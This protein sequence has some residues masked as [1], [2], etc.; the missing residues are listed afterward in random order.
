M[1]LNPFLR[2]VG[3]TFGF[4]WLFWVLAVMSGLDVSD[5]LVIVLFALG[6]I[7]PTVGGVVMTYLMGGRESLQDLLRRL[8]NVRQ[9]GWFWMAFCL[10]FPLFLAL[11]CLSIDVHLLGHSWD[12]TETLD[13]LTSVIGLL[14]LIVF[15]FLFGPLPEEIG[16]RGFGLDSLQ[17]VGERNLGWL[18]SSLILAVVWTLWH[19]PFPFS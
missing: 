12:S 17:G 15:A 16:W 1:N 10:F 13:V 3:I 8:T 7:G 2:Y 11:L 18:E 9:V 4:T 14:G 6:G 5:P 19:T